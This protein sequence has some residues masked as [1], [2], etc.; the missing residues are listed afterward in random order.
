MRDTFKELPVALGDVAGIREKLGSS[1]TDGEGHAWS[2]K[3]ACSTM[4][5]HAKLFRAIESGWR[6]ET[7][8]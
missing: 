6:P 2:N 7:C 4:H 3:R 1:H 8:S 5:G